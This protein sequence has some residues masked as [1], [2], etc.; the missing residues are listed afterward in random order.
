MSA[1]A[2]GRPSPM[3]TLDSRLRPWLFWVPP[4]AVLALVLA[5][6]TNWGRRFGDRPLP[7]TAPE[8][9]RVEVAL[10]P[11]FKIDGGL[12]AHSETAERPLF[13]PTR[14]PAPPAAP[15]SAAPK[16]QRGQFVLTGTAV[17]D[18]KAIAFLREVN[19]NKARSVK[20]GETINGLKVAE[21]RPD[22]VKLV[23]GDESEELVL[24]VAMGPK[25]TTQPALPG[26]GSVPGPGPAPAPAAG[27]QPV[28]AQPAPAATG[29]QNLLE[30][31]RA[32]RAA[33]AAGAAGNPET[34]MLD[35]LPLLPNT[36]AAPAPSAPPAS[37]PPVVG[38]GAAADADPRWADVYRRMQRNR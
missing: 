30:R 4:F 5:W 32:A 20:A 3:N 16:L 25:T 38:P 1:N 28:A 33:Q 37:T 15:A 18:T 26:A 9:Q 31:R 12:P 34:P 36:E 13:N 10:L 35:G 11:E 8:P 7:Q 29:Q 19:G 17:V 27:G 14:R 6:E 23:L 24:R 2:H 22:R 21:V